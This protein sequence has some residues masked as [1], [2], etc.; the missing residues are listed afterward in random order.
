MSTFVHLHLHTEYSL[1]DSV[2]RITSEGEGIPGLMDSVAAA[3]MPSVAL[4]DQSNLFAMVKFYKAAQSAGVKP[5]IGVDLRIYEPGDRAEPSALVL[6][7]QNPVGYNNLSKLVSRSYLQGQKKGVATVDR[8]WLN[9]EDLK[10]LIALS[11]AREGDIGRAILNG[12]DDEARSALDFWLNLFGDRFYLELQ[13]TGREGD[14]RH[15]Q[16]ALDLAI[17]RGIP[18]VATNDVRFIRRE[19]FESHEAR[20]CIH[21]GTLLADPKRRR[22]YSEQQYLKSPKEMAE[23]F[24][25]VPEALENTVEIAR[26]CSLELKLGKSVLPK[27]PTPG[28]MPVEDYLR[29]QSRKG[30]AQRLVQL[31]AAP[32]QGRVIPD[33]EYEQ[34]LEIELGVI[35]QMGFPGYFLIVADFIKWAKENGVPVGPG[36]GSGAGSLVAFCLGITDIDPLRYDLLFERFLN[37]ERVSMPDFDVDFCMDGRDRVIDYVAQHYGRERVSQ[38]I[39]YGT[40]AAK[41]VVR[42]VA[43]VFGQSYGF[44][45]SIAKLIPFELG[46]TL[47]DALAK[48]EELRRRYQN[49]EETRAILDMAMSLEGLVRNAGMHAGGVVISPS[50]L[51]DFS[52]LFCDENGQS[53]VTQFDKDDV[54]Q[55]GLVKFDF[56]GLRTL[57]IIDW[58]LKVIN[59]QR[60]EKGEPPLDMNALPMDDAATFDL[61]KRYET[62][63]VFQLESRGMKD[64]IRRLQPDCFEDI[65][66]LVALFR[67]GPLESGMV[68]DFIARK[69]GTTTGPI[70]YLHPDLQPVLAPTYGVILYQEQVM[71]IAQVLAGYSLG[72]ADLLRRAMGKK[73]PEEMAK[74]RTIFV[75]GATARGVDQH[76]AE[77]IFDLMEKFAGYGFNKSHSAA[78]ALLTYQTAW[79]KA[80]YPAAFMAAVLSSDMDKTDKVVTL[81][82][83]ARRMKLKVEP[84]DVNSSSFMFTVSNDRTI[85]YGLGAIKGVGQN[86]VEMLVEARKSG[87]YRD[88]ADMCRRSDANRMNRRVLEALIR[89][90]AVDSLGPNRATLMHSLPSAMQ[91]ADQTIRARAVGQDDMFGLMDTSPSAAP[92]V[93]T[94]VLPDWSRRVRL[95]G[96]RDTLGLYL[97]GHPFE[98]FEAEVKPITSGRIVDLTSDRP[99]PSGGEGGFQQFKGKP[100]TVGGMVFDVGKRGQRVIFTLDDRSGRMEASMF[101]D[102]WQQYRTVIAKSAIVIVEGQLRFDEYSESW[103]L[104]AK[105]VIDIDQARELHAKRLAIRWP[106]GLDPQGQR[107]FLKQLEQTLRPFRGGR[108]AVAVYYTGSAARAELVLSQ[109]WQVKPTR[110]LTERLSQLCGHD[111]FKLIYGPPGGS[112]GE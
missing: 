5:I 83:E 65:V 109:E 80:H 46:I 61:L 33:E 1:V 10:G 72:G 64:L 31:K 58:A 19:D 22:R 100:V 40:M 38:I 103:R 94:E 75:T 66:A 106:P 29:E 98:E 102:Q 101:E 9:P 82:D 91:L 81:I 51:T 13:R 93:V 30:L 48:E 34:R 18:V 23:L 85:R 15:V 110:E 108:C 97:T 105:K 96:E 43:R 35:I 32:V 74:Q 84:P 59:A 76:Q 6:L 92:Q 14:E 90:G 8:S 2:V 78:Y 11:G 52:P 67:P 86:V 111:G 47:K 79:L 36:R 41:A 28:D 42:D 20:V 53:V 49:E 55:A 45:D 89:S 39:T 87:P 95:D 7:C 71:Q 104:N 112:R 4:T 99:A 62:T 26:R 3:K 25:D 68:D 24:K 73:K 27:F 37:P 12:R 17:E 16:G 107:G 21:D 54:E 57:T 63:A 56:L 88:L 77:H 70:D 60:A 50:V 69:R 44:A